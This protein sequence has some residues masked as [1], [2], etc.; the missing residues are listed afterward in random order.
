MTCAFDQQILIGGSKGRQ[1][2]RIML[3][4]KRGSIPLFPACE[5]CQRKGWNGS[6]EN[7]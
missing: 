5:K 3:R 2:E 6:K 4:G 7:Q 1:V